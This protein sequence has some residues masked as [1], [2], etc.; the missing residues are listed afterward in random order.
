MR[1]WCIW[2]VD[3]VLIF[4]IDF[5]FVSWNQFIYGTNPSTPWWRSN[6]VHFAVHNFLGSYRG[7]SKLLSASGGSIIIITINRFPSLLMASFDSRFL[8]CFVR[9]WWNDW[10]LMELILVWLKCWDRICI[11]GFGEDFFVKINIRN[12]KMYH[13]YFQFREPEQIGQFSGDS[14]LFKV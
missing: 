12:I 9:Y 1:L 14:I 4:P 5:L 13:F 10:A 7:P 8:V 11:S 6:L 3:F 2:C